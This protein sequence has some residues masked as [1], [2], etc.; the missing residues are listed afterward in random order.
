MSLF[1]YLDNAIFLSHYNYLILFLIYNNFLFEK[2]YKKEIKMSTPPSNQELAKMPQDSSTY[3]NIIMGSAISG[4]IS[5]IDKDTVSWKNL[6]ILALLISASAISTIF[7]EI[8][9]DIHS[10]LKTEFRPFMSSAFSFTCSSISYFYNQFK[11]KPRPNKIVQFADEEICFTKREFNTKMTNDFVQGLINFLTYN[12]SEDIK[13]TF[14]INTEKMLEIE[15]NTT[16]G[17]KSQEEWSNIKIQYKGYNISFKNGLKLEFRTIGNTKTLTKN[18]VQNN[19]G[20]TLNID[21]DKVDKFESL[22]VDPI[23]RCILDDYIFTQ[24]YSITYNSSKLGPYDTYFSHIVKSQKIPVEKAKTAIFRLSIYM[25]EILSRNISNLPIERTYIQLCYLIEISRNITSLSDYFFDDEYLKIDSFKFKLFDREKLSDLQY[26]DKEMELLSPDNNYV[27][28][29]ISLLRDNNSI[30]FKETRKNISFEEYKN[31]LI[32]KEILGY[33]MSQNSFE[34]VVETKEESSEFNLISCKNF[35]NPIDDKI[36][37]FF[38]EFINSV[39]SFQ[40]NHKN[41]VTISTYYIKFVTEKVTKKISNPEFTKYKETEKKLSLLSNEEKNSVANQA[42]ISKF[43]N[44]ETPSEE[45]EEITYL[46]KLVQEKIDDTYKDLDTLYLKEQDEK[47]I[48]TLADNFINHRDKINKLGRKNKLCILLKG[49]PGVGKSS[50]ILSLASH[51]KKDIYY[52][53]WKEIE[54]NND[55]KLM[56][57]YIVKNCKGLI[58]AEDIDRVGNF[59]HKKNKSLKNETEIFDSQFEDLSFDFFLNMLDGTLTQEDFCFIA[60]TN[61]LEVLDEAF[62]RPGRMNAI[63]ELDKCNHYQIKKMFRKY[64]EREI[65]SKILQQIEEY[66]YIPG[67]IIDRLALFI[68][69]IDADDYTILEPFLTN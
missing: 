23:L 60:T 54:T 2:K 51:F 36:D 15:D 11:Y 48:F 56:I 63:I 26:I 66:K 29:Y 30:S 58:A 10:S 43:V 35:S 49:C 44:T 65:D 47:K 3:L 34:K 18:F 6:G 9:K 50:T 40:L 37:L 33:K 67:D 27:K 52:I 64:I 53:S 14:N 12:H 8:I 4:Y 16:G 22:F 45:I 46:K 13:C 19:L 41:N 20:L 39:K 25:L 17:I 1:L 68:N 38:M 24:P 21:L 62:L 55:L 7:T 31:S 5:R 69:N 57:D 42:I 28:R 61:N 32:G 59:A